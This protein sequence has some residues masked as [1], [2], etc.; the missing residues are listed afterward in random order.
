LFVQGKGQLV[1]RYVQDRNGD[2][3]VLQSLSTDQCDA[4]AAQAMVATDMN[5]SFD[6][7]RDISPEVAAILADS[8]HDI[9]ISRLI[10][11]PE[12]SAKALGRHTGTLAIGSI[13]TLSIE[14]ARVLAEHAG[15]LTIDAVDDLPE[16]VVAVLSPRLEEGKVLTTAIAEQ[17]L[18]DSDGVDLNAFTSINEDA[19]AILA[20]SENVLHLRGLTTLTD[21]AAAALASHIPAAAGRMSPT[22]AIGGYN[23]DCTLGPSGLRALAAYRGSLDLTCDLSDKS[24]DPEWQDPL[25]AFLGRQDQRLFK[26]F[27]PRILEAL[28]QKD[29]GDLRE[30]ADWTFSEAHGKSP[31]EVFEE[32][33]NLMTACGNRTVWMHTLDEDDEPKPFY[34]FL[35]DEDVVVKRIEALPDRT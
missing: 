13:E 9:T 21:E 8:P 35:G 3:G 6:E 28:E 16:D 14:P 25:S 1:G 19:A 30:L 26:S 15:R 31:W 24:E 33:R 34:F 12:A 22:L 10:S 2:V 27:S 20:T 4:D 18:T 5:L 11:L 17:F 32:F 29:M 7:L 23:G